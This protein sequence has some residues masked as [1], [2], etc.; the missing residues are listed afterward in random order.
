MLINKS[1]RNALHQFIKQ[2]SEIETPAKS[3]RLS[4]FVRLADKSG[5]G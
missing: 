1:A 3:S 2:Y 5:V 4:A